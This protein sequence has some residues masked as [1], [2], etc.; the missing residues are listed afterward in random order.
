MTAADTGTM[1]HGMNNLARASR[2]LK[3]QKK[4]SDA[5]R[6]VTGGD[7]LSLGGA[8]ATSLGDVVRTPQWL[9]SRSA[10]I[11]ASLSATAPQTSH[12]GV[13]SSPQPLLSLWDSKCCSPP[14]PIRGAKIRKNKNKQNPMPDLGGPRRCRG[15][16]RSGSGGRITGHVLTSLDP[17]R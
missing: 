12:C 1:G 11:G 9:V 13:R 15:P 17:D 5:P 6:I 8:F 7:S 2:S 4:G 3:K 16:P 10:P 14:V